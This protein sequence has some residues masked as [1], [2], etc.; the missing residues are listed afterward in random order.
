MKE[1]SV[2]KSLIATA[3]I[4]ALSFPAV[5]AASP[6]SGIKGK[7]VK[8]SYADLDLE[9]EAGAKS[10]YRRLQ[11]ASKEACGV[12]TLQNAGSVRVMAEMKRCYRETLTTVVKRVDNERVTKIHES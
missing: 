9:K 12:E 11:Q 10:L 4:V 1:S 6:E 8:V 7:S 2:V 3:T 5:A